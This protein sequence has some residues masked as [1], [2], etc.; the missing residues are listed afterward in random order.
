[1]QKALRLTNQTG[2]VLT[3]TPSPDGREVAFLSDRGGHANIWVLNLESGM[4]RQ[5]THER[6]PN[7]AVGLPTWS[8]TTAT[9][10]FISSRDAPVGVFGV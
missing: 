7:V 3:P 4:L 6:D 9:I 2:L 5:I 1:M 10:A 8:P